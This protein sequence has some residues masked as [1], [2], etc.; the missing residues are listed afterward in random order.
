MRIGIIGSMQFTDKMLEIRETLREMGLDAFVTELHKEMIGKT[1]EE[2][3]EMANEL[4]SLDEKIWYNL[5]R[6]I[7][8]TNLD[9][10]EYYWSSPPKEATIALLKELRKQNYPLK[11][12]K[13]IVQNRKKDVLLQPQHLEKLEHIEAE[14]RPSGWQPTFNNTNN[15][16][17]IN[18]QI[19]KNSMGSLTET[20]ITK[21]VS[22][23]CDFTLDWS[24]L[25]MK[26]NIYTIFKGTLNQERSY[27]TNEYIVELLKF[28]RQH[29]VPFK[30]YKYAVNGIANAVLYRPVHSEKLGGIKAEE[31]P[32]EYKP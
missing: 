12:Y 32:D 29:N 2:I 27:S 31:T 10:Q 17:N 1:D 6:L 5:D 11:Y 19:D 26:M 20:E 21:M 15:I 3:E 22:E 9:K 7:G 4:I 25:A 13:N 14:R 30:Y 18:T 24:S 16:N 23:F 28:C 8:T